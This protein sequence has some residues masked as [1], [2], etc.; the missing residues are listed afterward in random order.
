MNFVEVIHFE[1]RINGEGFPES[2]V[3]EARI[4]RNG[5]EIDPAKI[6][7]VLRERERAYIME[8]D[9]LPQNIREIKKTMRHPDLKVWV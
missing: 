6:Y 8:D 2:R 5:K 7:T 1:G 4:K 3:E 9:L